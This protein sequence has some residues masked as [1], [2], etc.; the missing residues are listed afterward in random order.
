MAN[1]HPTS[2][3]LLR[4]AAVTVT[5]SGPERTDRMFMH[6]SASQEPPL[7]PRCLRPRRGFISEHREYL[8]AGDIRRHAVQRA[9]SVEY[10]DQFRDRLKFAKPD[11]K[12]S[13]E[14]G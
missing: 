12:V 4:A 3:W 11:N 9:I 8:V 14:I 1:G 2:P 13:D 7:L 6:L 5:Q 10:Q